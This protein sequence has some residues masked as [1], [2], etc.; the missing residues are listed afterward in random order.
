M[1][2]RS[3]LMREGRCERRWERARAVV[4]VQEVAWRVWR[5]CEEVT[6]RRE[7][8]SKKGKEV[9]VR[10]R[11]EGKRERTVESHLGGRVE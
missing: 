6:E 1:E 11:S 3:R 9:R 2:E 7:E 8:W 4:L 5:G 10:V